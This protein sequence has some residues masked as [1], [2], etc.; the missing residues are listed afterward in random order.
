M[1]TDAKMEDEDF[2][3][4]T[5]ELGRSFFRLDEQND[6]EKYNVNSGETSMFDPQVLQ[7]LNQSVVQALPNV[8][9]AGIF[10]FDS[11]SNR[12]ELKKH[13]VP[14]QENLIKL[15]ADFEKFLAKDLEEIQKMQN[16]L[17]NCLQNMV[18]GAMTKHFDLKDGSTAKNA[19]SEEFIKIGVQALGK[20]VDKYQQVVGVKRK[21]MDDVIT[22]GD[23]IVQLLAQLDKTQFGSEQAKAVLENLKTK[24]RRLDQH[25]LLKVQ[26]LGDIQNIDLNQALA[27]IDIPSKKNKTVNLI[28][29][30]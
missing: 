26:T 8:Q 25:Q 12:N 7:Q 24:V 17:V 13:L 19:E 23:G 29:K 5:V 20:A 3:Q 2:E 16:Q 10:E 18:A 4:S 11:E 21:Q 28:N 27:K 9:N 22:T 15:V 1:P 30:K 14:L 6:Q